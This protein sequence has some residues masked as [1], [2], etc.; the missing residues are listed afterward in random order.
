[1]NS[2]LDIRALRL[3]FLL[4]DRYYYY[5]KYLMILLLSEQIYWCIFLD[6][7]LNI[8]YVFLY[9]N[10]FLRVRLFYLNNLIYYCRYWLIKW[11]LFFILEEDYILTIRLWFVWF[12]WFILFYCFLIY[13]FYIFFNLYVYFFKI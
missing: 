6:C 9:N 8:F 10:L 2:K 13:Y 5:Y 7:L 4:C 1:M 12:V 3:Y 11:L